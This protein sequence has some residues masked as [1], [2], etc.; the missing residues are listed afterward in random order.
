VLLVACASHESTEVRQQ[1]AA[2]ACA[3][4]GSFDPA[5]L[6][7]RAVAYARIPI[8]GSRLARVAYGGFAGTPAIGAF[9]TEIERA[10]LNFTG[11]LYRR[12]MLGNLGI[13]NYRALTFGAA[14]TPMPVPSFPGPFAD[15]VIH[16]PS[17]IIAAYGQPNPTGGVQLR[18]IKEYVDAYRKAARGQ[19]GGMPV[20]DVAEELIRYADGDTLDVDS[21]NMLVWRTM[22]DSARVRAEADAA[23][24]RYQNEAAGQAPGPRAL[25]G[26]FVVVKD[27]IDVATIPTTAGTRWR[28]TVPAADAATIANLRAHGA[29]VLAKSN[30]S[31]IGGNITGYNVHWSPVRNA[32]DRTK[33]GGGSSGGSAV[34]VATGLVPIAVGSDAGGSIRIPAAANGVYGLKPTYGRMSQTGVY[35][36]AES[37][38]QPGPLANTPGD[39]AALYIA[40]AGAPNDCKLGGGLVG[41]PDLGNFWGPGKKLQIGVYDGWNS[42]AAPNIRTKVSDAIARLVALGGQQ[43]RIDPA[44][45]G[46]PK[47]EWSLVAQLIT[48]ATSVRATVTGDPAYNAAQATAEQRITVSMGQTAAASSPTQL[49]SCA[50]VA[51]QPPC[52]VERAQLIRRELKEA[53]DKLFCDAGVD[54][55]ATFTIGQPMP[56][57]RDAQNTPSGGPASPDGETDLREME[58]IGLANALANLTGHP[59]ISIPVGYVNNMPVALQLIGREWSECDLM[60]IAQAYDRF[61]RARPETTYDPLTPSA[62]CACAPGDDCETAGCTPEGSCEVTRVADG[63]PCL[64]GGGVC[65]SGAC[66]PV[67]TV[68]CDDANECTEDSCTGAACTNEPLPSTSSCLGGL[69]A[70]DGAGACIPFDCGASCDDGNTCTTDV[71]GAFGCQA[72]AIDDGTA[73]PTGTCFDA[74]CSSGGDGG[75]DAGPDAGMPDAGVADA[76][77]WPDAGWPDAGMLD[78][79]PWPDAGGSDASWPD[80]GVLDA[81]LWPDAG[82]PDAGMTDALVWRDAGWPD[83]LPWLDAKWP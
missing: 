27:Q 65:A 19:A 43:R 17:A 42:Q 82:W 76:P 73:C 21:R 18:T 60:N 62:S 20:T 30:M 77:M 57:V 51:G 32:Y 46:I 22:A 1:A 39:L 63:T 55:I 47:L 64:V 67:C 81:P 58:S 79:P 24:R 14:L 7:A 8:A 49:S 31:E 75:P 35:P 16:P 41:G 69:G 13:V 40:M 45:F 12:T 53:L 66:V 6:P 3:E 68:P 23:E 36:L 70:C 26:V 34:A 59:A 37:L 38:S 78:A 33:V 25:E 15:Q 80:A 72:W 83:A 10:P 11:T 9:A 28:S 74:T 56:P 29:I 48:Y 71:C 4:R 52:D 44:G 50:F 54:V 5:K 2:A 61:T